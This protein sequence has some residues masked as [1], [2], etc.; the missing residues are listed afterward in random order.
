MEVSEWRGGVKKER[1]GR[2]KLELISYRLVWGFGG[3]KAEGGGEE[4]EVIGVGGLGGGRIFFA[5]FACFLFLFLLKLYSM[6]VE[7]E[8]GKHGE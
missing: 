6:W 1:G 5:L 7:R 3:E 2:Q 4:K 8:R